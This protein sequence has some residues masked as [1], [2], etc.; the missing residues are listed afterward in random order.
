M[1]EVKIKHWPAWRY[2]PDGKE[3]AIFER[4]KDVPKGWLDHQPKLEE[5]EN[6]E[7]ASPSED[8]T[9]QANEAHSE[10]ATSPV[11]PSLEENPETKAEEQAAEPTGEQPEGEPEKA[12]EEVK[13]KET[14]SS[15]K[16]KKSK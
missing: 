1:E 15:S 12:E 6:A 9:V 13:P 5:G 8:E 16:G 10:G 11:E 3:S 2:S 7:V 14:K 4:E